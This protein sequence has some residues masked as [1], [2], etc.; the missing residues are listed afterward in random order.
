MVELK[1]FIHGLQHLFTIN[2][3]RNKITILNFD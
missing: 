3:T 2:E 1:M